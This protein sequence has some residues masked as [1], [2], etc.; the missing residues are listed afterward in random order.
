[1]IDFKELRHD[2]SHHLGLGDVRLTIRQQEEIEA[3]IAAIRADLEA[4]LQTNRD[5]HDQLNRSRQDRMELLSENERLRELVQTA[6]L[7]ACREA[8]VALV[9]AFKLWN[10]SRARDV[11]RAD[12]QGGEG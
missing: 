11:L 4:S 5:I 7:E 9:S 10:R 1:M 3:E 8:N 12:E 6:F 2:P